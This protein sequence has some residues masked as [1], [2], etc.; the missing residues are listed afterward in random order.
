MEHL[1]LVKM[2]PDQKAAAA[3]N[4]KSAAQS[5]AAANLNKSGLLDEE[6]F[7]DFISRFQSKRMDD[8]RCSLAVPA[9]QNPPTSKSGGVQLPQQPPSNSAPA[10]KPGPG[11]TPARSESMKSKPSKPGG[12]SRSASEAH[13]SGPASLVGGGA[14]NVHRQMSAGTGGGGGAGRGGGG[15]QKDSELLEMIGNVQ[16]NRLNEQ[17]AAVPFLPGLHATRGGGNGKQPAEILQRL[18]VATNNEENFPDESFFEMLMKCQGS[19]LEEQRSSLPNEE[20]QA[21]NG[22]AVGASAGPNPHHNMPHKQPSTDGDAGVPQPPSMPAPPP[23]AP[24]VPDEDFFSLIQRLQAG[25][26]EDQRASLP[27]TGNGSAR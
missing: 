27:S 4:G 26:L 13:A 15:G 3:R 18:S 20:N 12:I 19:R 22:A 8:Q 1:D 14:A 9:L 11:A 7:F 5:P 23:H 6:D 16:S 24:T 21:P 10:R 17:R 25:R 2:T